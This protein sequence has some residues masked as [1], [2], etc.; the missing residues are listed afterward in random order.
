VTLRVRVGNVALGA[1]F[2][3]PVLAIWWVTR[4]DVI[5]FDPTAGLVLIALMFVAAGFSGGLSAGFV[6]GCVGALT[7]PG[8]YL[9]FGNFPFYNLR[10]FVMTM[11]T[12][13][14]VVMLL[15]AIGALLPRLGKH[16]ERLGRSIHAFV[17][18]WR[19]IPS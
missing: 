7:V 16:R 12:A 5:P 18:A 1:L 9:L 19:T 14:A 11:A 3:L 6:A 8:D 15:A 17:A 10:S 4:S 2:G 13:A